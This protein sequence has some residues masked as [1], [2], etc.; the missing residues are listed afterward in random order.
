MKTILIMSLIPLSKIPM[1][2]PNGVALANIDRNLNTC[3]NSMPLFYIAM[4]I[5]MPSAHL[6]ITIEIIRFTDSFIS[7][8]IPNAIP[9]NIA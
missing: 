2:V 9:S 3:L 4:Q 5:D 7:G 6:W 8:R 1:T